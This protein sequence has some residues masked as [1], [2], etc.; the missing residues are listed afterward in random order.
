MILKK[1]QVKTQRTTPHN[2]AFLVQLS[3]TCQLRTYTRIVDALIACL[4]N[5]SVGA[6]AVCE[7]HGLGGLSGAGDPRG[8]G[9]RL[10][11]GLPRMRQHQMGNSSP[12]HLVLTRRLVRVAVVEVAAGPEAGYFRR[13]NHR[14]PVGLFGRSARDCVHGKRV[15]PRLLRRREH[16]RRGGAR[17]R[18]RTGFMVRGRLCDLAGDWVHLAAFSASGGPHAPPRFSGVASSARERAGRSSR[19]LSARAERRREGHAARLRHGQQS[20]EP[21]FSCGVGGEEWKRWQWWWWQ[22]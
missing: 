9:R 16:C 12:S 19:R 5:H 18:F 20:R 13:Q 2:C 11:A 8:N 7:V 15:Y 21:F 6:G 17:S 10:A 22:Q 3:A 1:R 4:K 14:L